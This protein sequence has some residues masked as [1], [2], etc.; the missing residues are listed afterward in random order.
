MKVKF[1]STTHGKGKLFL[2]DESVNGVKAIHIDACV[3][4]TKE[5]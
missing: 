2:N 1:M 4:E 5:W 3:K